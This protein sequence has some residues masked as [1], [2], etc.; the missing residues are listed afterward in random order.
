[1]K[2]YH[3]YNRGV[4]KRNVFCDEKDYLRF[5]TGMREFMREFN[6]VEPIG[7]LHNKKNKKGIRRLPETSDA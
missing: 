7:S 6:S 5:L 4:D 2:H 1:M 3:I